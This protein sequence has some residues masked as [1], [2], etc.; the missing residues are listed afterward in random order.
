MVNHSF[1]DKLLENLLKLDNEKRSGIFHRD[2]TVDSFVLYATR[3]HAIPMYEIIQ[4]FTFK[5]SIRSF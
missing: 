2:W 5:K 1:D 3:M 4:N